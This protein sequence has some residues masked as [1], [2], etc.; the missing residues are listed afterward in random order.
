MKF[1]AHID[2][3]WSC[4]QYDLLPH[5]FDF[6]KVVAAWSQEGEK[7]KSNITWSGKIIHVRN[8]E[9]RSVEFFLLKAP[10][11]LWSTD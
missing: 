8:K 4:E 11:P 1:C 5:L 7:K 9:K 2:L 6:Q 3:K 10:R